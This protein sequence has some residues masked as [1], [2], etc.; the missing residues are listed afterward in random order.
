MN[1]EIFLCS[2]RE[3]YYVSK[4]DYAAKNILSNFCQQIPSLYH[5]KFVFHFVFLCDKT[6][7]D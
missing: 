7:A 6:N 5:R 3:K 1:K 2:K 4:S